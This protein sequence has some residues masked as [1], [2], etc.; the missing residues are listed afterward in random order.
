MYIQYIRIISVIHISIHSIMLVF[1]QKH[2]YVALQ[3][4]CIYLNYEQIRWEVP[5]CSHRQQTEFTL[6]YTKYNQNISKTVGI[7]SKIRYYIL[8]SALVTLYYSLIYP[9]LTSGICALGSTTLNHFWPLITQHKSAIRAIIPSSPRQHSA[10]LVKSLNMLNIKPLH[11]LS[12]V[13]IVSLKP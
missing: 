8:R 4:Y 5:Q 10:P 2:L 3:Q 9:Y 1:L 13:C 7:L 6:S 11:I 12:S